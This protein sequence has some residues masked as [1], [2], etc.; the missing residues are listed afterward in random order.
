[1]LVGQGLWGDSCFNFL[2]LPDFF[3]R[4]PYF[5][6]A[7]LEQTMH[8]AVLS[9]CCFFNLLYFQNFLSFSDKSLR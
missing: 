6:F 3:E 1:M 4:E 5:L 9:L 8:N 7:I 2:E